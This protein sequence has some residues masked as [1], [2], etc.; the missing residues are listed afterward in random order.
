[1]FCPILSFHVF[2]CE[3]THGLWPFVMYTFL[4]QRKHHFI[5]QL[6]GFV[7]T[8]KGYVGGYRPSS[9]VPPK[10]LLALKSVLFEQK[11]V[12]GKD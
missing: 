12:R 10:G 11:C 9:T 2:L 5:L 4:G 6:T 3:L 8:R 7:E 1:M